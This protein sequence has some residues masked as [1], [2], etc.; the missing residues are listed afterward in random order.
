L[1][2]LGSSWV[3]GALADNAKHNQQGR[4]DE[5]GALRHRI[6]ELCPVGALARMLFA[7]FHV[8]GQPVPSF[9]PDYS[10]QG[11]GEYG[12]REWYEHV[13]FYGDKDVKTEMSYDSAV[14]TLFHS[15]SS[16]NM[17]LLTDHNKRISIIHKANHVDI[18]KVTHA[19]RN[20][21]TM[22]TRA[23][24]ASSSGTKALGG[25]NESGSFRSCYDRAFPL[26]AL[27]GAASFNAHRP[28]DYFLPRDELRKSSALIIF[29]G[30]QT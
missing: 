3:L 12:R 13:V 16:L 18:T 19:S 17:L 26:D 9:E 22:N 14:S 6:V 11:F 30:F 25:W 1:T 2:I 24:G 21:G 20:Y 29:Q 7:Y 8:I 5:Y 23:N 15:C 4:V 28:E 10:D 27:L